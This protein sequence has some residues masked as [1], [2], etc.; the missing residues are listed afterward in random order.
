MKKTIV[1]LLII[2]GI[3]N[4]AISQSSFDGVKAVQ[5]KDVGA[6]TENGE[7][8]GY[9]MFYRLDKAAKG[10]DLFA[11]SILDNNLQ[12]THYI[13][14]KK[15][16]DI[17]LLASSYNGSHFCFSFLD[18]NEKNLVYEVYDNTLKLAGKFKV[19]ELSNVEISMASA[20]Y[21]TEKG[22][23]EGIAA[24]PGKGFVRYGYEK[25]KGVRVD[26]DAFNN[27]GK[28]LWSANSGVDSKKSFESALPAYAD[29][30]VLV[31]TLN[32]RPKM[33]STKDM[34][35]FV[36]FHNAATG[37]EIFKLDMGALKYSFSANDVSYDKDKDEYILA[38]EYFEKDEIKSLG[39][40]LLRVSATGKMLS[41]NYSTWTEDIAN[42]APSNGK[43]SLSD[44]RSIFIHKVVYTPDGKVFAICEQFKKELS[45]GAAAAKVAAT[46]LGGS[47][48][49]A[50]KIATYDMVLFEFDNNLK[51]K[52]ISVIEKEKTN[53]TLPAGT[54]VNGSTT[55]GYFV[56]ALGGFDYN[57]TA[58]SADKKTFNSC[59]TNYDREEGASN[60]Y[61]IGSISYTKEQK[62]AT[63][64]IRLKDKPTEFI[65]LPAKPGYVAIFK[66]Y[67]KEKKIDVAL[68]KLNL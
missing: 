38:G 52:N 51:I 55:L 17:L 4:Q 53:I 34:Q 12:K 35:S 16:S 48:P 47:G 45:G 14:F 11:L 39:L 63:D 65:A 15:S 5:F 66:Y 50:F 37:K 46:L 49:S 19:S 18:P 28:K 21:N 22:S 33:L 30:K 2:L 26:L 59:Y 24:L 3:N 1:L 10:Q 61:V 54:G 27:L 29:E 6:I 8:K 23:N 44:G 42:A 40:C 68:E 60:N 58:N 56:K 57:Y 7:V 25:E 20:N 67:K 41:E 13:E 32:V 9:Y 31:S 36:V 43:A 62:I 64:K